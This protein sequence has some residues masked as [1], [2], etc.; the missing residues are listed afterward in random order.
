MR[1][2]GF[3]VLT[4]AASGEPAALAAIRAAE[5]AGP[6]PLPLRPLLADEAA[7]VDRLVARIAPGS[8]TLSARPIV[9]REWAP[10]RPVR[11]PID[12][13]DGAAFRLLVA[14][15]D[16]DGHDGQLCVLRAGRAVPGPLPTERSVPDVATIPLRRGDVVVLAPDTA[17]GA[18]PNH[19]DGTRVLL[20]LEVC[21]SP[22]LDLPAVQRGRRDHVGPDGFRLVDALDRSQVVG[23]REVIDRLELP[24]DHGFFASPKDANGTV[25]RDTDLAI[26][27]VV[28]DRLPALVPGYRPFMVA[29]T[30]KGGVRGGPVPF[31]HDW[32][33]VDERESRVVFLWCPLVDT[34]RTN[35]GLAVVPGSHR[36]T[37]TIRP[38]RIPDSAVVTE[39]PQEA[40]AAMSV[41]VDVP[42]GAALMFDP[43]VIHGSDR[44]PKATPRPA[45]TIAL[46]AD[47]VSLVHFHEDSSGELTGYEVD[48]EFFTTAPFRHR[49]V[50]Y[51]PLRP[52]DRAVAEVDL[53]EGIRQHGPHE[54]RA[55]CGGVPSEI[56][57]S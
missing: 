13:S 55:M 46:A 27:A 50:G 11:T 57:D 28:G 19:T 12:A 44:N 2:D 52:W 37:D 51:P 54:L 53:W 42:A 34:D 32:T 45:V 16:I 5:L 41:G 4:G 29:V 17:I 40:F 14:C 21:S 35:G 24:D 23:I 25:A 3:A 7:A 47:D 36:W 10:S 22:S 39:E 33:Y 9:T 20:E 31:H 6:S 26:R 38:S 18:H 56:E 15:D 43:A 8:R 30:S 49:P 1:R 48:E